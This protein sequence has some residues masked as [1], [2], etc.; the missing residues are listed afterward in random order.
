ML[1]LKIA[2]AQSRYLLNFSRKN[3]YLASAGPKNA[4]CRADCSRNCHTERCPS[5]RRRNRVAYYLP[6]T[7]SH[8]LAF[9]PQQHDNLLPI[10]PSR[11]KDHRPPP[12]VPLFSRKTQQLAD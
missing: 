11:Q 3:I 8:L 6:P 9:L 4:G 7:T 5:S 1:L 2:V 10:E 12:Q